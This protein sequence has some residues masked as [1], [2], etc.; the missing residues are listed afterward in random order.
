MGEEGSKGSE[1]EREKKKRTGRRQG[2][3]EPGR[4]SKVKGQTGTGDWREGMQK[5]RY[6]NHQTKICISQRARKLKVG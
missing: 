1:K 2:K 3:G 5:D 4:G 6:N